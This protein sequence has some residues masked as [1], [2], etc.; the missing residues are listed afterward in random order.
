LK[1][2][3]RPSGVPVTVIGKVPVGVA[4]VVEIVSRLVQVGLHELRVNPA[5]AP[6][7][8]PDAARLT[9]WVV[10]DSSV[11]VIVVDPPLPW[12][13]VIGPELPSA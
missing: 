10:P 7:G 12:V 2:V 4:A 1:L 3:V 11:A 6:A 5:V 13:T 8:S 9:V